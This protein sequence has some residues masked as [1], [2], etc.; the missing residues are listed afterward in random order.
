MEAPFVVDN[1]GHGNFKCRYLILLRCGYSS[2][3]THIDDT[4]T[5]MRC[6]A[7][8]R[9]IFQPKLLCLI[10]SNFFVDYKGLKF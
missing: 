9:Y 5:V 2:Y 3:K 8:L 6:Y 1:H 7:I 10:M 4:K